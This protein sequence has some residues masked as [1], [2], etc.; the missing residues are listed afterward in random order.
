MNIN[1]QRFSLSEYILDFNSQK[2][3]LRCLDAYD[4][5]VIWIKKLADISFISAVSEN[6]DKFFL[7]C[8]IDELSGKFAAIYKENGSTAWFIPGRDFLNVIYGRNL[9]LIFI[10]EREV[11]YFIKIELNT[12]QRIWHHIIEKDLENYTI[13]FNEILLQY[14]SGRVERLNPATGRPI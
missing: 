7:S 4:E 11:Y 9:F 3:M 2:S 6:D 5:D 12:G 8:Q 1:V 10:D 13:N 14:K